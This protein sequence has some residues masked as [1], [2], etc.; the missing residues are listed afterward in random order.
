[1]KRP[2][3]TVVELVVVLITIAVLAGF[4]IPAIAVYRENGRT[5]VCQNNLRELGVGMNLSAQRDPAKKFC[6]NAYDLR[7][8]GC[9]D[10]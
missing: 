3:Y 10:R 7:R 6:S 5:N 2:A 1:M 4:L 9:H 8:D